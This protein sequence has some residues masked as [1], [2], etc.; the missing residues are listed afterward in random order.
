MGYEASTEMGQDYMIH[1]RFRFLLLNDKTVSS[2]FTARVQGFSEKC[3][4]VHHAGELIKNTCC[5]L[6]EPK[7]NIFFSKVFWLLRYIKG[8]SFL[9]M[10]EHPVL[11]FKVISDISI[12]NIN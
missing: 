2:H 3:E 5:M 8:T 7:W 1:L 4:K 11:L 12:N 9:I 10:K 6:T